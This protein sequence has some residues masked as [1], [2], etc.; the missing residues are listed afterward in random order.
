MYRKI[1]DMNFREYDGNFVLVGDTGNFLQDSDIEEPFYGYMYIDKN[2]GIVMVILG[3]EENGEKYVHEEYL[4]NAPYQCVKDFGIEIIDERDYE[5][6]EIVHMIYDEESQLNEDVLE[7]RD[8]EKLDKFRTEYNPDILNCLLVN[9]GGNPVQI[10]AKIKKYIE[11]KD[12]IIVELLNETHILA[13]AKIV[14]FENFETLVIF[15][16]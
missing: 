1:N 9:R 6:A 5:Y 15:E 14:E 7:T 13:L 4:L 10:L 11:K 8:I 3:N 16:S 2:E 12:I